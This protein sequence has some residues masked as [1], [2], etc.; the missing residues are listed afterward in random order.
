MPRAARS[1]ARRADRS[2]W[3]SAADVALRSAAVTDFTRSPHSMFETL[4][5]TM[6]TSVSRQVQAGQAR[7]AA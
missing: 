5:T 4:K 2:T 3:T 6:P 7:Q 1:E